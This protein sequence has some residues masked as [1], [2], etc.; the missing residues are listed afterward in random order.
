M[1]DFISSFTSMTAKDPLLLLVGAVALVIVLTVL[2]RGYWVLVTHLAIFAFIRLLYMA[3]CIGAVAVVYLFVQAMFGPVEERATKFLY[4]I[5][6]AAC[7]V[8]VFRLMLTD[9]VIV[10]FAKKFTIDGELPE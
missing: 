9:N 10:R 1:S 7:W 6:I 3:M 4:A 8:L 2:Y 5:I